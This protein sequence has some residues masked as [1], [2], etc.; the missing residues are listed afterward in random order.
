[1]CELAPERNAGNLCRFV[2]AS[3]AKK[4]RSYALEALE[5]LVAT[6]FALTR[7]G[8]DHPHAV[9]TDGEIFLR[10]RRLDAPWRRNR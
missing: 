3:G 10:R 2:I 5:R 9:P 6:L 4:L 7:G 8:A 1:M